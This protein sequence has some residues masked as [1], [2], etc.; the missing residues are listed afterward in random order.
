MYGSQLYK[1]SSPAERNLVK[2][3]IAVV[4]CR[5][6]DNLV[7]GDVMLLHC[8]NAHPSYNLGVYTNV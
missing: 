4:H 2:Y 7:K 1:C 6:K 3:Y 5:V 8:Q